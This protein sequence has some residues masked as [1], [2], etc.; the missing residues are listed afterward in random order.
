MRKEKV[1]KQRVKKPGLFERLGID[2]KKAKF[3]I[4]VFLV[5]F[6]LLGIT[7]AVR[8]LESQSDLIVWWIATA[9]CGCVAAGITIFSMKI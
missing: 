8:T 7:A 1:K 2:S 5:L 3:W 9:I 4:R 6:I